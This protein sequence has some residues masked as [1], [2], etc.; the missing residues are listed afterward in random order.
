MKTISSHWVKTADNTK[1]CTV[2]SVTR[3]NETVYRFSGWNPLSVREWAVLSGWLL[4]NGWEMAVVRK[5]IT[6]DTPSGEPVTEKDWQ[7]KYPETMV[8]RNTVYR[9]LKVKGLSQLI[10]YK[11]NDSHSDAPDRMMIFKDG[12][13][14]F[15]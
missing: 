8:R 3:N 6:G 5:D 11:K 2:I 10:V 15:R 9:K 4:A 14:V 7:S 12:T 1:R 13:V